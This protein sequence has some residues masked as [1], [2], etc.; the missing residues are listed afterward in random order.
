MY[1]MEEQMHV[2][3]LEKKNK[4]KKGRYK[5]KKGDTSTKLV[6]AVLLV[7]LVLFIYFVGFLCTYQWERVRPD[8][9]SRFVGR[10]FNYASVTQDQYFDIISTLFNTILLSIVTT[11]VS[12]IIGLLLGLFAAKNLSNKGVSVVIRAFAGFIRSVPTIIWVLIFVSGFGLTA[13]TALVGMCFH[14]IAYFIKAYSESFEEVSDG[15]IEALRATGASWWQ[16]VFSA[17]VP[18]SLTKLVSWMSMRT[19]LNFA[20]AVIIGP[21]VGVPGTIGSLINKSGREGTYQIM[22]VCILCIV[23]VMLLFE[24][25]ITRYKQKS[26]VSE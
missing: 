14:S 1:P 21:A 18:A 7:F 10:F 11:V 13:T 25:V 24:I 4:S 16:I 2:M 8:L 9:V 20:A 12:T 22:G 15:T 17:V 6:Y 5:L 3:S 23:V 26:I 19:E